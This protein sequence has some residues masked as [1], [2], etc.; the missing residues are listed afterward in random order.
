M[1]NKHSVLCLPSS[2]LSWHLATPFGR[3][4][5]GDKAIKATQYTVNGAT[6]IVSETVTQQ[7]SHGEMLEAENI[8]TKVESFSMIRF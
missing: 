4:H 7:A 2:P 6:F 8:S 1:N 5:K 3:R